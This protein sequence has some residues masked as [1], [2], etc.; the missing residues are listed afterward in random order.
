VKDPLDRWVTR[1]D[2]SNFAIVTGGVP[3]PITAF[4]ERDKEYLIEFDATGSSANVSVVLQQ[5]R[6][7]PPLQADLKH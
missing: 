5:P 3:C 7:M 2:P 6:G 1:L 4:V